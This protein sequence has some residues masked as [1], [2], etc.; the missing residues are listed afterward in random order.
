MMRCFILPFFNTPEEPHPRFI[1]LI[2]LCVYIHTKTGERRL[3]G[4]GWGEEANEH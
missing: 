1:C 4:G 3:F 2:F